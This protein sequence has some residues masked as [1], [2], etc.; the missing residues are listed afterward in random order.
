MAREIAL[1]HDDQL[2]SENRLSLQEYLQSQDLQF[3]YGARRTY[4]HLYGD[5]EPTYFL[6]DSPHQSEFTRKKDQ[7]YESL[8]HTID[9]TDGIISDAIPFTIA[10]ASN[11]Y[12]LF[13]GHESNEIIDEAQFRLCRGFILELG[14][15]WSSYR[16]LQL[17]SG[18][19][20]TLYDIDRTAGKNQFNTVLLNLML[21]RMPQ[22]V[23]HQ[24]NIETKQGYFDNVSIVTVDHNF[25]IE[26]IVDLQNMT[27]TKNIIH[28]YSSGISDKQ[29]PWIIL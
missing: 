5:R 25:Q 11:F 17:D 22:S 19:S 27:F 29:M 9:E 13:H 2:A 1:Q 16:I 26:Q 3:A 10:K 7:Q 6:K 4:F 18:K 28:S 21:E 23:A 15:F 14:G 12:H 20:R 24:K 8:T